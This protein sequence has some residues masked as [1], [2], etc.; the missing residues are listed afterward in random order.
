[1]R[2]ALDLRG[3]SRARRAQP[4]APGDRRSGCGPG[5]IDRQ[6]VSSLLAAPNHRP[7]STL[8]R[9]CTLFL[10]LVLAL[11][12]LAIGWGRAQASWF[13]SCCENEGW[14]TLDGGALSWVCASDSLDFSHVLD[15]RAGVDMPTLGQCIKQNDYEAAK[16]VA[17][18]LIRK[19]KCVHVS[20]AEL[21]FYLFKY[22]AQAAT[23][24][25]RIRGENQ[26]VYVFHEAVVE[27]GTKRKLA[28]EEVQFVSW[29]QQETARGYQQPAENRDGSSA[30]GSSPVARTLDREVLGIGL[31]MSIPAVGQLFTMRERADPVVALL[32]DYGVDASDK[33]T[34]GTVL[35]K[36][37]FVLTSPL[38]QPR[39]P[40]G[41]KS[42]DVEFVQDSL[43]QIGIHYDH[44]Y[45]DKIG[46]RE[47]V[48]TF[49]RSFGEPT[50][51]SASHREWSD[52]TTRISVAYSGSI[53]NVHYTDLAAER[54]IGETE[55]KLKGNRPRTAP[56]A[57]LPGTGAG[58]TAAQDDDV[59]CFVIVD[60]EADFGPPP[61]TVHFTTET[62][63]T[64]SPV[65]FVWNF[66]DGTKGGNAPNPTHV[67]QKAG[68]YVATVST[69]APDGGAGQ[70]E[71]AIT[72][73]KDL[74]D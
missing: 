74:A 63:C 21:E 59:D 69:I 11:S 16:T 49:V 60:A 29:A 6:I 23:R 14:Y 58:G 44:A 33:R 53:V 18:Q 67:Y 57:A 34:A 13:G 8:T 45:V 41:I 2:P 30:I 36:N 51:G 43:Y 1:M 72:V 15:R 17:G 62:D 3:W 50:D 54:M 48:A 73:D 40:A 52:R 5:G 10:L 68:D 24:M 4:D 65:T 35:N 27:K 31:G 47:F 46:W 38:L 12:F 55:F 28:G 20:N 70:D 32:Q 71:I 64:G 7:L 19:S 9:I 42:V 26:Y 56:G 25:A 37:S 61:L 22:A 66:G 39:F